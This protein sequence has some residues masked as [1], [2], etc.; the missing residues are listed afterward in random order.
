MPVTVNC[1]VDKGMKMSDTTRITQ[2]RT[3]L[4]YNNSFAHLFRVKVYNDDGTAMDL[5]GVG[6]TGHFT[7]ANHATVE[8]IIGSIADGNA[9]EV[10]LPPACYAVTGRFTFTMNL[11][12]TVDG[13]SYIRTAMWVEGI[14]KRGTSDT[15]I[16]PGTPVTNY[17]T[18]ITN[19]N[20]AAQAASTAA[21]Q[22]N[23]A[24]Q[25]AQSA[26]QYSVRYDSSQSLSAAQKTTA[27]GNIG[28]TAVDDGNGNI[29]FN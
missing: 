24:A 2:L 18:I 28:L 7:N 29:T 3:P 23:T 21:T 9:A 6:V 17:E 10:I 5:S 8:P 16:D 26:A 27:R 25:A 19:A 12:S 14:V 13:D 22:A 4:V 11:T 20:A 15:P 1:V